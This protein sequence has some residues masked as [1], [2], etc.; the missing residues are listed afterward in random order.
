MNNQK[1][2]KGNEAVP[3]PLAHMPDCV[4]K[5]PIVLL[6]S[7][8]CRLVRICIEAEGTREQVMAQL[9]PLPQAARG[10]FNGQAP[11]ERIKP[12]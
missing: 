5:P 12:W 10:Y 3:F 1:S 6:Q 8:L 11:G 9:S 4:K 2:H 7:L